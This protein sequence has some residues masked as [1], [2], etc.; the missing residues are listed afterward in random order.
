MLIAY[1]VPL[2]CADATDHE[3]GDG[4]IMTGEGASRGEDLYL[5]GGAGAD[6]DLIAA[7]RNALPRLLQEIERL[8]ATGVAAE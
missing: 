3:S 6:Q 1:R 8:R 2:L 7:A 5:S 4:F